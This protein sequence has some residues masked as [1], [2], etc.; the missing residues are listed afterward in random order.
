MGT[1]QIDP[2]GLRLAIDVMEMPVR[3]RVVIPQVAEDRRMMGVSMCADEMGAAVGQGF[4]GSGE[5]VVVLGHG[6]RRGRPE[7]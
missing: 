4:P 5:A 3:L 6:S 7:N 2:V 1:L